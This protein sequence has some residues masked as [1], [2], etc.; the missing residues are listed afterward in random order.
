MAGLRRSTDDRNRAA[1]LGRSLFDSIVIVPAALEPTPVAWERLRAGTGSQ[2]TLELDVDLA[3]LWFWFH[4]QPRPCF[5]PQVLEEI[6]SVQRQIAAGRGMIAIDGRTVMLRYVVAASKSPGVF[7]L[8]GDLSLFLECIGAK[9]TERLSRYARDCVDT[10]LHHFNGY[11]CHLNT[12]SLVQG[13][14]YG[15]GFECALASEL[16]IAESQAEFGFPEIKFNLFPGMGG[17]TL[18]KRKADARLADKLIVEGGVHSAA[19]MARA[20]VIDI[21]CETGTGVAVVRERIRQS[22]RD[23]RGQLLRFMRDATMPLTGAELQA[24][25]DSW[26]EAALR[27]REQDL[28]LIRRLMT[29]QGTL[30]SSNRA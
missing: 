10:I 21:V 1:G 9:D 14:A 6:L 20:G 24:S 23:K 22:S 11:A 16:I 30:A 5:N 3:T 19:D 4:P 29:A 2:L 27:L 7:N 13:R 26:V 12:I 18:T 15:G 28:K 25:I 8:G 17:F